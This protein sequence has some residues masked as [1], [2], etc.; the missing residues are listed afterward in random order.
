MGLGIEG[1]V[2]TCPLPLAVSELGHV[3]ELSEVNF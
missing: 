1:V 3:L 2:G